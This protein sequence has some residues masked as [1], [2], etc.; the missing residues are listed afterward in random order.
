M[1]FTF[2]YFAGLH[3]NKLRSMLLCTAAS[4]SIGA[5]DSEEYRHFTRERINL[6]KTAA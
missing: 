2:L 4:M 5:R 6:R 1:Y 3:F